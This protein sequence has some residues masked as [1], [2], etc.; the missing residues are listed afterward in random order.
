LRE[1]IAVVLLATEKPNRE[2][3]TAEARTELGA[4]FDRL[5]DE[6]RTLSIEDVTA[7]TT[8]LGSMPTAEFRVP[9]R[10]EPAVPAVVDAPT[11]AT[12]RVLALGPLQVFSGTTLIDS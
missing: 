4:E 9:S 6:G 1:R 10:E 2:R 7:L 5:Y 11:P 12:L 8:E 3:I